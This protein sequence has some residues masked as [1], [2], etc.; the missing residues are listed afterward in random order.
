MG[1]PNKE[2]ARKLRLLAR[3]WSMYGIPDI[4]TATLALYDAFGCA[5]MST[6]QAFQV[7]ADYVDGDG[8]YINCDEGWGMC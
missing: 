1:A 5:D 3:D 7:I 4:L 8:D 2:V 6:C